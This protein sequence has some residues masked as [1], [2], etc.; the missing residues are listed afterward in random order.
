[1]N[2][3]PDRWS[4]DM[5]TWLFDFAFDTFKN[6]VKRFMGKRGYSGKLI[7]SK[8]QKHQEAVLKSIGEKPDERPDT[9]S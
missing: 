9:R 5:A 6:I 8:A 4:G 2:M 1:M 3:H 7:G